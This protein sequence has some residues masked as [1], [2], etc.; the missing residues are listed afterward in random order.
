MTKGSKRLR[1]CAWAALSPALTCATAHAQSSVTLYG[2]VDESVRYMTHVNKNGDSS[3]GLGNGGMSESRWGLR[4]V[5]DLGGGWST[6]FKLENRIYINS[7]QSDPTLPFFNEAQIGVQSSSYGRLIFGRMPNVLIEGITFGGYGSNP[8]I[9]YD[10]SFQ[11]EVTMS[12]G[13]WTSNQV[14]YQARAHDVLLSVGYA[15]G[16]VAGHQSYGSQYGA[17]LAYAPSGGPVSLGGAYEESRDSVNG[18]AAKAWTFGASYTWNQTRFALGYIVNQNDAGF[19]NFANGPFTAPVLAALKYTDFSRRRMIMG[20]ITQQVGAAW[21]FAA[22]VWRTLQD[23]KTPAQDGSAWQ[24]QLVADYSL[25]KRTDVYVEGDYSLYR[26][27]LIGAQL[28]GVNGV[29]L[30]QKGTQIGLM[31]GLRHL[32]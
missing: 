22:N 6:F 24:Y 16:G 14:Q 25:S 12:G 17:A 2:I 28:Q 30:A 31:A 4:G 11:P 5:E 20:G 18:S 13:I 21:H 19:S 29:G 10:F 26:G 27:D 15:F 9:P 3:V 7:G 23:G 1:F 32:F 8:W